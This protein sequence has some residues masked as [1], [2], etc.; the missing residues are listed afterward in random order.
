MQPA[1][2]LHILE[3]ALDPHDPLADQAAVDLQ[4]TLTGAAEEAEA[5]ALALQVGPGFDQPAALIGERGKLDLQ[6]TFLGAGPLAEDLED[7][8]GA[9]DDL[10]LPGP[11]QVAL[12]D[13]RQR[14]IDDGDLDRRLGDDVAELLDGTA[15]DQGRR[16]KLAQPDHLGM[17][18]L[19]IDGEGEAN[20]LSQARFG[21]TNPVAAAATQQRR[22]NQS[23]S[24]RIRSAVARGM[25]VA[26]RQTH[27]RRL[28]P[29]SRPRRAAPAQQASPSRLRV[30]RQAANAHRDAT[31]PRNYRTK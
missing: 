12:L 13:R 23:T 31:A 7:Q 29:P 19:E 27:S 24:R 30:Y 28:R 4:L 1:R 16:P 26:W 17:H 10:A 22:Q 9:V 5:A 14:R 8:A 21:R 6:L 3:V 15:A 20:R 18:D 11:L 2:A 25:A